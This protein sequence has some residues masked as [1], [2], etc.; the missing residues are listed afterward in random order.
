VQIKRKHYLLLGISALWLLLPAIGSG[1]FGDVEISGL[2]SV[3]TGMTRNE[4][5][6][7]LGTPRRQNDRTALS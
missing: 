5:T 2:V 1:S 7:L 6:A 3:K 4:V